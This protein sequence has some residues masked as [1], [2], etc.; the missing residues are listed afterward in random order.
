LCATWSARPSVVD[1][2]RSVEPSAGDFALPLPQDKAT[3]DRKTTARRD[4]PRTP[5]DS[6]SD[7][8]LPM[9]VESSRMVADIT[10]NLPI[11]DGSQ[12][13]LVFGGFSSPGLVNLAFWGR[14]ALSASGRD[15]IEHTSRSCRPVSAKRSVFANLFERSCCEMRAGRC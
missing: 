12:A 9:P 2:V 15:V 13:N 3:Y 7:S 1:I 5:G 10:T 6:T 4:R 11:N 8:P 14:R